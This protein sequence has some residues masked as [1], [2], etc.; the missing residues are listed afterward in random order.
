MNDL[1]FFDIGY[2]FL[3][4][5]GNCSQDN[6][7]N[8]CCDIHSSNAPIQNLGSLHMYPNYRHRGVR[9]GRVYQVLKI[10]SEPKDRFYSQY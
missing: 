3:A 10:Y 1:I 2:Y 5:G 6:Y 9:K 4:C 7:R 8:Y